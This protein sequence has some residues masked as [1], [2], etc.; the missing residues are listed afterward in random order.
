MGR[1]R[2]D[3][4]AEDERFVL[5]FALFSSLCDSKWVLEKPGVFDG[6]CEDYV[7]EAFRK[8]MLFRSLWFE[9]LGLS[10]VSNFLPWEEGVYEERLSSFVCSCRRD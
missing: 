10:D 8:Y 6:S 4:F 7:A 5:N 2:F 1:G 9:G 3:V